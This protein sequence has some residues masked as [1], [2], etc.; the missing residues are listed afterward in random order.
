MLITQPLPAQLPLYSERRRSHSVYAVYDAVIPMASENPACKAHPFWADRA[1]HY[2]SC[3]AP[4][5][6]TGSVLPPRTAHQAERPEGRSA[7]PGT[8]IRRRDSENPMAGGTTEDRSRGNGSA[9]HA[10]RLDRVVRCRQH[11]RRI[12]SFAVC[13]SLKALSLARARHRSDPYENR[14]R[15]LAG[16]GGSRVVVQTNR[17]TARHWRSAGRFTASYPQILVV[18]PLNTWFAQINRPRAIRRT[19]TINGTKSRYKARAQWG[20]CCK[21]YRTASNSVFRWFSDSLDCRVSYAAAD[22]VPAVHF[23]REAVAQMTGS[24]AWRQAGNRSQ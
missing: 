12:D 17:R 15:D 24:E 18:Q 3:R 22:P 7:R 20:D 19:R 2:R 23:L 10:I 14:A 6:R 9:A 5:T 11:H 4:M 1:R 21:R 8:R 13:A 16:G